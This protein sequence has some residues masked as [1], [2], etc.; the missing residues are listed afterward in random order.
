[1]YTF[2]AGPVFS[3]RTKWLTPFAHA[4]FGGATIGEGGGSG[5]AFSMGLGGGMD[6]NTGEH[7]ALRL[8]QADWIL[9]HAGGDTAKKN[10]RVSTGLVFRF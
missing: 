10:V 5:G 8:L 4:L 7:L 3:V 9:L 1:M 2:M 6:V